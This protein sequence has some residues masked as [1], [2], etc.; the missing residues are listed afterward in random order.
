MFDQTISYTID[1]SFLEFAAGKEP[2]ASNRS[3]FRLPAFGH[4]STIINHWSIELR[5][6]EA[7]AL[8]RGPLAKW[9]LD[10][11]QQL[12]RDVEPI[13]Q[14]AE[15]EK[16]TKAFTQKRLAMREPRIRVFESVASPF[17]SRVSTLCLLPESWC[18]N[19]QDDRGV[20]SSKSPERPLSFTVLC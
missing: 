8:K 20:S 14:V 5:G 6:V 12:P 3:D 10:S 15:F 7:P 17:Q 4:Q 18:E 9:H 1:F 16:G 2:P 13:Q 11:E 19:D